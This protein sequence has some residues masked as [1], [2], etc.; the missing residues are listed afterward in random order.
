M[1]YQI[2]SQE[3]GLK[4]TLGPKVALSDKMQGIALPE[5][6]NTR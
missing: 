5:E 4:V 2:A 3:L 1:G 6:S